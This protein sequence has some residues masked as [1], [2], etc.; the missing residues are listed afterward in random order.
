MKG[1]Q[2]KKINVSSHRGELLQQMK[3]SNMT[4]VTKYVTWKGTI[5]ET[6]VVIALITPSSRQHIIII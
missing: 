2:D 3:K 5:S 1:H 6:E 4:L